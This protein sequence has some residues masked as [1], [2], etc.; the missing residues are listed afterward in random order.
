MD[1]ERK[2]TQKN[3][4]SNTDPQQSPASRENTLKGFRHEIPSISLPKGGGAIRG[5]GEK[6]AANPVTGTG[7]LSVPIATS[8]GRSGFGPQLSLS[9]D[10]GSGNGPFGFGWNLSLP[11]ITR[12]TDKGL[13]KYHDADESDTF[14]LS[15]AE[16]L[17]PVLEQQGNNWVP[18]DVPDRTIG[19]DTYLIKRYRPRIEGLFARIERWS[20][21]DDPVDT[22][23]RSIS[24]DNITSWYGKTDNS[25]IVDPNNSAY[26]FNWLICESYD[27]KGNVILYEY[28]EENSQRVDQSQVQ[29]RNRTDQSRSTN[30]Y[31]KFIKYGNKA[32]RLPRPNDYQTQG[33]H[34]QVVFDYGEGHYT[35]VS[36][37]GDDPFYI[38]STP[39]PP[40]GGEWPVRQDPFSTSRAG[41]EIRTYRLCRRVLMFHDFE[42]LGDTPCL[43]RSTEF[44]YDQNKVSTFLTTA[45]QSGYV[46]QHDSNDNFINQYLKKSL[47]SLDFTYSKV[48]TEQE[49]AALPVEEID[50]ESIENLPIGLD[51]GQYQWVDLDGEGISGILSKQSSAWYYKENR[52]DGQFGPMT[53][54]A[55]QPSL[56][57]NGGSHQLLDL[58]GDGQLDVVMFDAPAPGFYERSLDAAWHS[59]KTFESL[60]N[61]AWDDPNLKF[62]D[63]TG[64]GH[65]DL[66]ISEDD[67]FVWHASL[68]E[69]G[70]SPAQRVL[71]TLDEEKGPRLVFADITQSIF[72]SDMSGDGLTDL[73]RIRNGEV[74]YWPNLGY[75]RFGA[76]ITM[77]N[78]PW[79][80]EPDQFDQKRIRLADT[81]G[82]GVVDILYLRHDGIQLYF[83]QS[84]NGWSNRVSLPQ[85]VH[86]DNM[87]SFQVVD[88]LG[89]GTACLVW[90]SSLPGDRRSPM[91]YVDLMAGQKP[92]LLIKKENNLGAETHVHYVSSTKFYL[93]D[94]KA[95]KPWITRI[96]FPVHVVERVETYDR[97]SRNRFVT[98]YAYHHG[99]FDGQ[100][101]EFRGFGMVEQWD[102]EEYAAL[103]QSQEFP[104]GDNVD[105]SSHVPP[106]HTKIWFHTG[107]YLKRQRISNY[108]ETEYYW[109][110]GLDPDQA[111]Q[112]LLEDTVLPP[113]LTIEEEREAYRALKGQMLRQEVY[114]LDGTDKEPHP[115]TVTE[116]NFTIKCL[117]GKADNRHAVF[118]THAQEAINYHY[119]RNPE[120]PRTS[121]ALTLE[122]DNYGN[123]LKS[124]AIAY[125]RREKIKVIEADGSVSEIQNPKLSELDTKDQNKQTQKL[126]TYTENDVTVND[127][128]FDPDNYR[129][130]LPC[131]A[132]TYE[133]TGLVPE[134][135][136]QRFSFK[137]LTDIN[138]KKIR[139]L[140]V[141]PYQQPIDYTASRK[142]LIEHVRTLYRK[143]NMTG[144]LGL[145]VLEPLALPGESYKLAFTLGLIGEVFQRPKDVIQ[146]LGLPPPVNLLPNP[147]SVLLGQ[148]TDLG[149]YV[150]LDSDD[151]WWIPSGQVFY[152]QDAKADDP[153][154]T[155]AQELT[156]ARA[157]FYLPRKYTDPFMQSTTVDYHHDL[158]VSIT[159]DA[160]DN[161]V[162]AVND[163]RVL[164]PKKVIDPNKNR[165]FATFDARGLVVATAV[166]GKEAENLGDTL[167]DFYNDAT[168]TLANPALVTLQ[169]FVNDPRAEAEGLLKRATTRSVYDLGRFSRTFKANPEE[170]D[171]WQPPFA[172]TL[173]RETHVSDLQGAQKSKIQISL[174]YSDGFGREIQKK[175]QA[176]AGDAP[177]RNPKTVALGNGDIMP[178]PLV[179]ENG[180]PK[181]QHT[182][183]RWVGKGRT[184]FNNKGKPVKQYEPFFSSTHLYEQ[185]PDMTMTGVTPIL[186]YDPVGRVVATLHPNHTWEKVVF[187]PWRQVTFDVNDA[188]AFTPSVDDDV[189]GFF[190][191]PDGTPRIPSSEYL[192]TWHELRTDPLHAVEFAERYPDATD[193]SNETGAAAKAAAHAD[194]PTTAYFDTLG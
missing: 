161:I 19:T 176:E 186:F 11:S 57:V 67:A 31:L 145:G 10:S 103:T 6:F 51:G 7:S 154:A 93:K 168:L 13:P 120:D 41:F 62:V 8:P 155:A 160:L 12:K 178:G 23:W 35:N 102:T 144:F 182:N 36:A 37:N 27:D 14:I 28:K 181:Q 121:H 26:I 177:E 151:H 34:F 190:L 64:D 118:F 125:G 105:L 175:I 104:T 61:I 3:I 49:L 86:V 110:L 129:T 53:A 123:V 46:R 38:E 132:R 40:S 157:H 116:Q 156:E 131:E 42:S 140:T 136:A 73:I 45:N 146:T 185:E 101:R 76:K 87:A 163:F 94:K 127:P 56:A 113:D 115:Y 72:L 66:I 4:V 142:R 21:Q 170:P 153:A 159:K 139:D 39:V 80:E 126:I 99:Y 81:D 122:V 194:T 77:D 187:D 152:H 100:E 2:I 137:E 183:H 84:G 18:E 74:C 96:P 30:R 169:A 109:E 32:S 107:A 114:A 54:V 25:R 47:P 17:V 70:Y 184:V 88:L 164:Q 75:G 117:Q 33:W 133:L 15:G 111:K 79:F 68:A 171:K 138:N 108:F 29:E 143:D 97:I 192:P 83:N 58:A 44:D 147:A 16:D 149:G 173:A 59:F 191:N 106:V 22:F 69:K 135:G 95:G 50:Q 180:K 179:I 98:R 60:P 85:F 134:G 71:K 52:G 92:H 89:K 193:R 82:T 112:L 172:A 63:L 65:A 158:L 24:K 5:I 166:A 162:E 20:N 119:E 150:D 90:S 167:D 130:P 78:S 1:G 124:L 165:S 141:V 189:K 174:S 43:V 9:Y 91:K 48:P 188:V 128:N 55:E 148:G